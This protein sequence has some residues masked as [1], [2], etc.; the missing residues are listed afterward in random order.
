MIQWEIYIFIVVYIVYDS[1]YH[2]PTQNLLNNG[3]L[4]KYHTIIRI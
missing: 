1:Q 4:Q 3:I 2:L